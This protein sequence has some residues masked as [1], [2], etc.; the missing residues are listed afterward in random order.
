MRLP[1]LTYPGAFHHVTS[2]GIKG[3]KI[4]GGDSDKRCFLELL[5][6]KSKLNGIRVFAYCLMDNHYHLVIENSSGRLSHFL[7]Q[8]NGQYGMRYRKKTESQGYV[9]QNRFYSSLIQDE[10]YLTLAIKYVLLNPVKAGLTKDASAYPWSS[11]SAYFSKSGSDRCATHFVEGLFGSRQALTAALH[12]SIDAR[13]PLVK[14]RFGPVIG[15]ED[16]LEKA[17]EKFDR[18]EPP[19]DSKGMCAEGQFFVPA[20]KVIH[21][22]EAKHRIK[23]GKIDCSTHAGK[24]LRGELLVW[25]HDLAGLTYSEIAE[26]PLF[27][28]LKFQSLGHLY[29]KARRRADEKVKN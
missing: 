9:F 20:D 8:L 5:A 17:A 1:R 16:F 21:E 25:L 15:N 26:F 18:R 6:N 24:R 19:E 2:R 3:E 22:F 13:L 14:T 28:G 7:R 10:A 11:A 29:Q 12:G 4:L 27:S 23:T